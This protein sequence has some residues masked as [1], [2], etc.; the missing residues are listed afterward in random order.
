MKGDDKAAMDQATQALMEASK[1]LMEWFAKAQA[2][3]GQAHDASA[4]KPA[5]EDVVD[6][7]FEEVKDEKK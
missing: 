4:E 2:E 1:P 7:E 3:Q 6:A 5:Q